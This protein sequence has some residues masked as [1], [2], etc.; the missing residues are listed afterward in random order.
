MPL[1]L[2]DYPVLRVSDTVE[3]NTM[4]T[5]PINQLAQEALSDAMRHGQRRRFAR[6]LFRKSNKLLS[7]M[8]ITAAL[9][10][11][12]RH[13][14]G[15]HAVP[16]N[17]IVGSVGRCQEF[18]RSFAPCKTIERERWVCIA[19]AYYEDVALPSIEL[20]KAGEMYFVVDGNHRISVASAL[21]QQTIDPHVTEIEVD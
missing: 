14:V 4:S 6:W 20:Y 10:N 13:Y 11:K 8:E 1:P 5:Q 15:V 18:D 21:G 3:D 12:G 17:N 16:L 9:Q 19:K 2:N 7:F